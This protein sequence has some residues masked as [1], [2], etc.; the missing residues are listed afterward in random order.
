MTQLTDA[1]TVVQPTPPKPIPAPSPEDPQLYPKL[2]DAQLQTISQTAVCQCYNAGSKLFDH[3]QPHAPFFVL[4]HG[5]VQFFDRNTT[6]TAD[7]EPFVTVEAGNI[8]GDIAMFTGEP[9]VAECVAKTDAQVLRLEPDQLRQLIA[10]HA[11]IGDKILTAFIARRAW[12][13]GHGIG[14]IKLLGSRWS[15]E[16][17]RLR[18]FLARNQ[19]LHQFY[20]LERDQEATELLDRF[21][22]AP[23]DTP[24]TICPQGVCR[25]PSIEQLASHLGLRQTVDHTRVVDLLIVGAGPAGLAAAVYA[26]SEGLDTLVIEGDSPGGQAG[27]SSKIENYLGFP[28][29][30]S[31]Q[32]L[33]ER[34]TLQARKF[35]AT[36]TNPARVTA[37]DC[38]GTYKT[39]TLDEGEHAQ[40]LQARTVII[41]TG[42]EYRKLRIDGCDRFDNQGVYY[43]ASHSE[44]VQCKGECV[45]VVGGGNSAG[46]AAVN[47][48]KHANEV[49]ILIRRAN[50]CSS[51]SKYLIERINKTDNITLHPHTEI[52]S[53]NGDARLDS[54]TTT[55][56]QT[57]ETGHLGCTSAYIMIGA[58]P[59]TDWLHDCCLLDAKGFVLTGNNAAQHPDFASHWS[60]DRSPHYLETSSPNVFAV[61]DVRA[62]SIKRVA[63]AVGEGSMCLRY[64]HDALATLT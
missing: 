62:G 50:L 1:P 16:A 26:A 51:M 18:D 56:N 60:L 59:R 40:Q 58:A 27:T 39:I 47:L 45:V 28:T 9:T 34:A 14:T 61:G 38:H 10:E 49:H 32:D 52:Q 15:P 35:G 37:I 44:A 17:F 64:V 22:I 23:E 13:K 19:V 63:S 55:H 48:A 3:G 33:A 36:L 7:P 6:N 46:Q 25:N 53:L 42:A 2:T 20:D 21:G 31:G 54:V 29:G 4:E 8:L 57:G 12:L 41:A 43:G 24:V 5:T 11:D 30:L